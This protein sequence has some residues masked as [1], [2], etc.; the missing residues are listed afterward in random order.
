MFDVRTDDDQHRSEFGH[1][2]AKYRGSL[3]AR[4]VKRGRSCETYRPQ[5][6]FE[7]SSWP[8][9]A[10]PSTTFAAYSSFLPPLSPV[11]GVAEFLLPSSS[12]STRTRDERSRSRAPWVNRS[13]RSWPLSSHFSSRAT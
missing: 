10:A 12:R 5:S 8:M 3:L 2:S 11:R 9:L 13:A 4:S 7:Q 1:G 6:P